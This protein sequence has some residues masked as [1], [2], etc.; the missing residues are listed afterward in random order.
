MSQ[1]GSGTA[2]FEA[3]RYGLA[4]YLG[5]RSSRVRF[6]AMISGLVGSTR[7]EKGIQEIVM[8]QQ[9][10]DGQVGHRQH[11]TLYL[12]QSAETTK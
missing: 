12:F 8:S 6:A 9:V 1:R 7:Q 2:R 3:H 5:S 10:L 11:R 4:D